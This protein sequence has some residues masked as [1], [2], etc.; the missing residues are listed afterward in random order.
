MSALL[1]SGR[2][3]ASPDELAAAY[4]YATGGGGGSGDADTDCR[5]PLTLGHLAAFA[6][7]GSDVGGGSAQVADDRDGTGA[8]ISRGG[9]GRSDWS[10]WV[11]VARPGDGGPAARRALVKA[12]VKC[13][14]AGL[15]GRSFPGEA[16][17]RLDPEG[18]G[19]VSRPAFKR[20]LREMGFALV[21]ETPEDNSE[22]LVGGDEQWR[23]LK[24]EGRAVGKGRG[25][26]LGSILEEAQVAG[27]DDDEV[28]LRRAEREEHEEAKITAFREKIKDIERSTAEKVR[29]LALAPGTVSS[30]L[31]RWRSCLFSP[32]LILSIWCLLLWNP[33]LT[34]RN[35]K[36]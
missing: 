1:S 19:R 6:T 29:L 13:R 21:D 23:M 16:F 4:R 17:S 33:S 22:G 3:R 25:G 10:S 15:L 34:A 9:G 28:R 30:K 20:A 5:H 18:A 36:S 26:G 7:Y 31:G 24:D 27:H 12:R 35:L 8:S 2:V 32:A 14:D 11:G